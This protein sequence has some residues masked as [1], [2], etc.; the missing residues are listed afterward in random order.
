MANRNIILLN[1]GKMKKTS[2]QMAVIICYYLQNYKAYL[3][4]MM[5]QFVVIVGI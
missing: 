2:V 3:I 1:V 5:K 4:I